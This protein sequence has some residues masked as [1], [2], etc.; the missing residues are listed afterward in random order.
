MVR[1]N[2]LPGVGDGSSCMQ[3]VLAYPAPS[4]GG[5][6]QSPVGCLQGWGRC[7]LQQCFMG[8]LSLF[9]G[10][11]TKGWMLTAHGCY[12]CI[13]SE[14]KVGKVCVSCIKTAQGWGQAHLWLQRTNP[15]RAHTQK[16]SMGY[17]TGLKKGICILLEVKKQPGAAALR[18]L[19]PHVLTRCKMK[20]GDF[21][22]A[23]GHRYEGE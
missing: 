7:A 11:E 14:M 15:A 9:A 22:T 16:M 13:S 5:W 10:V 4:F 8:F 3:N 2:W 17:C 21:L 20:M 6:H 1:L 19:P 23:L 18:I 12:F